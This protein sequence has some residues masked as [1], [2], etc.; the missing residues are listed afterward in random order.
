[1]EMTIKQISVSEL[2]SASNHDV[3]FDMYSHEGKSSVVVC[4]DS[5]SIDTYTMFEYAGMIDIVALFAEE[6]IV[7]FII[8]LTTI[9]PHYSKLSTT[10]ESQFIIEEHRKYGAWREM[11][12]MVENLAKERGS[13]NMFITAPESSV[14]DKIATFYGY[15]HMSNVYGKTI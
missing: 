7:G 13:V 1:M 11:M 9:M 6:N 8:A 15:T 4:K 10:I 2:F 14:L 5:P 3:M 12:T